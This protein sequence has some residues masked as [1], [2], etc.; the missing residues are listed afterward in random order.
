[1]VIGVFAQVL[2]AVAGNQGL[3]V[4]DQQLTTWRLGAG[5][6]VGRV[7]VVTVDDRLLRS[8]RGSPFGKVSDVATGKG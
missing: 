4:I 5:M 1:L 3:T 7:R 6:S 2:A 8:F